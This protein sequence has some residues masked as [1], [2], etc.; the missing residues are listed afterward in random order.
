MYG[1]THLVRNLIKVE[2]DANL[3]FPVYLEPKELFEDEICQATSK[4]NYWIG[5]TTIRN[6]FQ[7]IIEHKGTGF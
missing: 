2:V 1:G 7:E 3:F 4:V 5:Q 6:I